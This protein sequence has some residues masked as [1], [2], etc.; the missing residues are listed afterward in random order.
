MTCDLFVGL[1]AFVAFGLGVTNALYPH[2]LV[3]F[4]DM[5][6]RRSP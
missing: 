5:I 6:H 4:V 2:W 3:D 1:L